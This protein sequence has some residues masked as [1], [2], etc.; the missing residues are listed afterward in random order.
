VKKPGRNLGDLIRR[1]EKGAL[2][3][4]R[5]LAESADLSYELERSSSNLFGGNG[6]REVKERFDIPAHSNI[7]I[8][9]VSEV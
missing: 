4:L 5:R 6:G 8:A 3:C 2:V 9:E 7:S 1:R